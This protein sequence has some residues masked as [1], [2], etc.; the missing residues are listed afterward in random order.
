[1]KNIKFIDLCA[2]IGGFRL[3]FEKEGA[4]CNLSC[5]IDKYA[6]QTYLA[7]FKENTFEKDI[8]KINEKKIDDFDILC[9]GFPCQAFSLAGKQRGFEDTRGTIFFDIARILKEKIPAMF[10]LENVKNLKNHAKGNTFKVICKTLDDLNYW[11]ETITVNAKYYVPQKRERIYIIGL[12]KESN[13]KEDFKLLIKKIKKSYEDQQQLTLPEFKS[14][15]EQN[16]ESYTL[17]DKLWSFLQQHAK[18]HAAKGNGFGFGLMTSEDNT[19]RTLTARYHKDG[20][21]VL[22]EQLNKNPRK[23]SPRECARLMGFPD[24]FNIVV[25][26]TQSYKQFGNSVV[27]PVISLFAHHMVNYLKEK[28]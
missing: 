2:G 28:P 27:V 8:T 12:K 18:K 24:N 13:S 17:S 7:N 19:S 1:M 23:L 6:Q 15:L 3:A 22:V 9:A 5:E 20:S 26:K 21:E 14:I 16:N 11:H 4:Q 25:S 10:L